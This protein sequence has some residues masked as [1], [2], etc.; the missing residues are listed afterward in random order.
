MKESLI[1]AEDKDPA[2][3]SV[4]PKSQDN[5]CAAIVSIN[6]QAICATAMTA[7]FRLIAQEG[8]HAIDYNLVRNVQGLFLAAI[9][10]FVAGQNPLT[11]FPRDQKLT[12]FFRMVCGQLNFMMLMLAAPLAPLSL[13]MVCYLT[14]PFWVSIIA[15]F[16]LGER[17]IVA[18][19]FAILICFSA[20]VVIA[21]QQK[22]EGA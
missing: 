9:W 6:L 5:K 3:P 13:I 21:L 14:S 4:V 17:I 15:F 19:V 11:L 1:S 18:E 20:V 16:A 22:Q 8:F 10:L 7:T 2:S 12:L